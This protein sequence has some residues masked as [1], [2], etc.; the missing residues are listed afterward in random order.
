[1]GKAISLIFCGV[2]LLFQT[3]SASAQNPIKHGGKIETKYDGFALETVMK[4]RKMKVN[5]TGF[6]SD[7]HDTCVSIDVVLHC[8]GTQLSHVGNVTMQ[9]IFETKSWDQSH[10]PHQRDLTLVADTQTIKLGRMRLMPQVSTETQDRSTETLEATFRYEVFKKMVSSESVEM[11]V[12]PSAFTLSEKN[13]LAL[14][15]LNNRI[16]K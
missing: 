6:K 4:L 10:E 7:F 5:C 16:V 14:R 2:V 1:M 13:L 9:L 3:Y 11:K 12:G 8:P 15:D